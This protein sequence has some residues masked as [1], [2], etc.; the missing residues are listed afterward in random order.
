MRHFSHLK[1]RLLDFLFFML[2][3]GLGLLLVFASL[4]TLGSISCKLQLAN[5]IVT[6]SCELVL[7]KYENVGLLMVV[8]LAQLISGFLIIIPLTMRI[9]AFLAMILL[10]GVSIKLFLEGATSAAWINV[11]VIIALLMLVAIAR[12]RRY[13]N[14]P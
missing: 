12:S 8:A 14:I 7:E 6:Q 1:Y 5:N 4:Q 13:R 3:W 11:A 9:G 10:A 2:R